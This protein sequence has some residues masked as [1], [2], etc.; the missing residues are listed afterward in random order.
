VAPQSKR[1]S[2]GIYFE[3]FDGTKV[4]ALREELPGL[5]AG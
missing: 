5:K 4:P 2:D 3:L 1:L